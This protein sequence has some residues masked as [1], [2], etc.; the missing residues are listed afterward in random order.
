MSTPEQNAEQIAANTAAIAGL[1]AAV[2]FL[3]S[4]FIRPNAQQHQQS[5]ERLER[6]EGI[7]EGIAQR[8]EETI[9]QQQ[10]NARQIAQN[11]EGVTQYRQLLE[12]TRQLVAQ[13]ASNIAQGGA[14]H[15]K[16]M[17]E[18]RASQARN[19]EQIERL[20]TVQERLGAF[21]ARND[22]HLSRI[23]AA[24]DR[25]DEQIARLST[26]VQAIAEATRTQLAAIIG[27][28]RRIDRL[29]QQAS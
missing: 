3:V 13:N 19:D 16:E 8:L 23:S 20:G 4:E 26:E 14:R 29:E 24:Q 25:N 11:A 17:A 9:T 28:G 22:E 18:I 1:N 10:A 2:N 21:Q 6:V 12:E 5:L 27:N 7:V 15:A